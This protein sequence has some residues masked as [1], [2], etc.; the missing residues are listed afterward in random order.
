MV[1]IVNLNLVCFSHKGGNVNGK[2]CLDHMLTA[3]LRIVFKKH[4]HEIV[5]FSP[6]R[7]RLVGIVQISLTP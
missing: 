7:F 3:G 1:L 2:R 5:M 4:F 6:E